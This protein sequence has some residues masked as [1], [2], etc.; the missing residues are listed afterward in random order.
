MIVKTLD[1]I[2]GTDREVT[3][4]SQNWTSFRFLL[5]NEGMGFTFHETKIRPGTETHI[6]YKNHLE[7]V[8]CVAGKGEIETIKDGKIYPIQDGTMYALNEH[9]E[10]YLRAQEE[11]RLI[12]VFNPPVSGNEVHDADGVYSSEEDHI[13]NYL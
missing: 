12:C 1:E 4:K 11:L 5:K 3:P 8:Y 2:K 10:H 6:H 13:H 9:D 7:A